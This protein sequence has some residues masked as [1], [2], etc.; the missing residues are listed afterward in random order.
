MSEFKT[1]RPQ[2][3]VTLYFTLIEVFEGIVA[4]ALGRWMAD[5][6]SSHFDGRWHSIVWWTT[7]IVGTLTIF[8]GLLYSIGWLAHRGD[9]HADNR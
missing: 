7:A 9:R 5:R 3:H 2:Q 4:Y 6:F 8:L 1:E